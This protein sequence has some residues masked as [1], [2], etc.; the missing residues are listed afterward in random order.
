MNK[1]G[2]K[3]LKVI[4]FIGVFSY[5]Q[6]HDVNRGTFT[7]NSVTAGIMMGSAAYLLASLFGIVLSLSRNYF[8]AIVG[9]AALAL[10]LAFKLDEVIAKT[11]WLT[12]GRAAVVLGV[13]AVICLIGDI[14][15]V[16]K[17]LVAS[18]SWQEPPATEKEDPNISMRN[19]MKTNPQSVLNLSNMLE[20]QWG[21]KPTYEEVMDYIDH[22]AIP[23]DD[24]R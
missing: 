2:T 15:A 20:K 12:E 9:T 4:L 23:E 22:L 6:Y 13:F 24:L 10:F 21:R 19:N 18:K 14:L 8:I 3:L 16:K 7:I 11:S 5:L 17:S 1:A